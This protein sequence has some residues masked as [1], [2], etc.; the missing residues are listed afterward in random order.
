MITEIAQKFVRGCMKIFCVFPIKRNRIIFNSQKGTQYACSPRSIFEYLYQKYGDQLQYV[1]CLQN[2]PEELK[3][4]SN[5]KFVTYNS[6]NYYYYQMTS[7][8]IVANIPSPCYVPRRKKQFM[9][10]TW[11]G[12]GAYK[13][14]GIT[15]PKRTSLSKLSNSIIKTTEASDNTKWE[16]YKAYYNAIDTSLFLCSC[17]AFVDVIHEA[18]MIPKEICMEIGLPRNDVFFR[19]N[20]IFGEKAKERLGIETD[21]KVI[22]FAPT[23]R[24]NAKNQQYEMNLDIQMCI[25]AAKEIQNACAK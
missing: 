9:I 8:V 12:G 7:M 10:D 1:W 22:L 20:K 4:I 19:D 24:G 3:R 13:K 15:A 21:K 23:Y 18:Q 5:V 11:H 2:P 17:K 16:L 14:F 25:D 6:L